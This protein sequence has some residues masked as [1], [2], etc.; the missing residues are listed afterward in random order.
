[1][2]AMQAVSHIIAVTWLPAF[3]HNDKQVYA[4][5]YSKG[6]TISLG[7]TIWCNNNKNK[8]IYHT[9]SIRP[10]PSKISPL[11]LI[12]PSFQ[13]KKVNKPALSIKPRLHSFNYSWLINDRLY[14]SIQ[15]VKLHVD[16]SRMVYLPTGSADLIL[17]LGCMMSNLLVLELFHFVF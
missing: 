5:F 9:S 10:G 16:W 15:T 7:K 13:G 17:I 1:M 3:S 2:P 11:P 12:S 4:S 6:L 14:Q 8:F